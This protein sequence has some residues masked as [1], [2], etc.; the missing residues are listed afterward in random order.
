MPN[1]QF[2]AFFTTIQYLVL[3]KPEKMKT[4]SFEILMNGQV[5]LLFSELCLESSKKKKE[6]RVQSTY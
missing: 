2:F 1:S 3:Y 5:N 6:N 4:R